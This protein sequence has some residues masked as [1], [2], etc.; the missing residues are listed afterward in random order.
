[1][2]DHGAP[3]QAISAMLEHVRLSTSE[4]YARV[5]VGRMQTL[6]RSRT[7]G[8]K[9]S[10]DGGF[11]IQIWS[12]SPAHPLATQKPVFDLAASNADATHKHEDRVDREHERSGEQNAPDQQNVDDECQGAR[13]DGAIIG[14]TLRLRQIQFLKWGRPAPSRGMTF[15]IACFPLESDA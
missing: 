15:P 2:H 3:I 9:L 4:I 10:D 6:L 11:R 13:H 14:P 1:M 12:A 5:S 8:K 7:H